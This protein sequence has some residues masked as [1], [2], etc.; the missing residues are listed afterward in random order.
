H[1]R[2]EHLLLRLEVE[3]DTTLREPCG[4]RDVLHA[5]RVVAAID[6]AAPRGGEDLIAACLLGQMA[7]HSSSRQNSS[8]TTNRPP[9]R[10]S[11]ER[12]RSSR[13]GGYSPRPAAEVN[14][15]CLLQRR[16]ARA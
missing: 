13:W 9:S 6:E 5:R 3:V 1:E 7:G 11:F 4:A 12:Q 14:A 10:L 16:S 2:I 8:D 15:R